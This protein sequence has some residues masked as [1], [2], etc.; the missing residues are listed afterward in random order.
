MSQRNGQGGVGVSGNML[1]NLV[2]HVCGQVLGYGQAAV[3]A[4]LPSAAAAPF[5]PAPGDTGW[6]P[7][8]LKVFSNNFRFAENVT[9]MVRDGEAR[10]LVALEG[11][12]ARQPYY[13]EG[14]GLNVGLFGAVDLAR[15]LALLAHKGGEGWAR[16][17]ARVRTALQERER[18]GCAMKRLVVEDSMKLS[19]AEVLFNTYASIHKRI[20]IWGSFSEDQLESWGAYSWHELRSVDRRLWMMLGWDYHK[21]TFGVRALAPGS[22]SSDLQE[23]DEEEEGEDG[24]ALA[25]TRFHRKFTPEEEAARRKLELRRE[26]AR[27]WHALEAKRA[28][29]FCPHA[30]H[31]TW[32]Q[33]TEEQRL[34]ATSLNVSPR[35]RRDMWEKC[36]D[37]TRFS[38]SNMLLSLRDS[39][40]GVWGLIAISAVL[41]S[42]LGAGVVL[43]WRLIGDAKPKAS[44]KLYTQGFRAVSR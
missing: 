23:K 34:A 43:S 2:L 8:E 4:A 40:R 25:G 9:K 20:V 6:N 38:I 13:R 1:R 21:W 12:S 11:D 15:M 28:L 26:E 16:D 18:L 30:G 17:D 19:V 3:Q 31:A 35:H 37:V 5:L 27:R 7:H 44:N 29:V 22:S 42:T 32:D 24:A 36:G 33:L 14:N 39:L 41:L 10:L